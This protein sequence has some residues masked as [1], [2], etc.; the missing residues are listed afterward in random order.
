MEDGG[1]KEEDGD[2][3]IPFLRKVPLFTG[4]VVL[5]ILVVG[6]ANTAFVL[7]LLYAH[8]GVVAVVQFVLSLFKTIWNLGISPYI[9]RWVTCRI[10]STDVPSPSTCE[11]KSDLF[12]LQ[13]L[14]TMIN[15]IVIPCCT[16]A[17]IDPNCF[18]GIFFQASQVD[19]E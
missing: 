16:V 17:V 11:V 10:A 1:W 13:L 14:L 3:E 7:T 8:S 18:S 9:A 5:N 2:E 15:N 4:L 6:G 19:S 12:Y